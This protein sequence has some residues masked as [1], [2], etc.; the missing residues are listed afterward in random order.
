MLADRESGLSSREESTMLAKRLEI[1]AERFFSDFALAWFAWDWMKPMSACVRSVSTVTRPLFATVT[2][3]LFAAVPEAHPM[4][5]DTKE[6]AWYKSAA[7]SGLVTV[8]WFAWD[9]MKPMSAC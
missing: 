5:S 2:R 1:S 4:V 7:N 8:A 3:P 6:L 9:W